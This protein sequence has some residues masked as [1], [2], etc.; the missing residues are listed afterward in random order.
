MEILALTNFLAWMQHDEAASQI[1][2]IELC[3]AGVAVQLIAEKEK[4]ILDN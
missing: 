3:Y 4:I 1:N 2:S